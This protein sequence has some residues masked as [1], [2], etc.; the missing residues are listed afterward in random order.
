MTLRSISAFVFPD[1]TPSKIESSP[2]VYR[3]VSPLDLYVDETY[4]RN[5]SRRSIGLI[6]RILAGWDWRA[7]KPP[8][9]VDVEGSLHLI[10][11][12]H[13]ALAAACHPEIARIPVQVVDADETQ[14][15]EAFVRHNRDRISVTPVQL[16]HAMRAAGDS[17]AQAVDRVC[18][19]A[20]ITIV[21]STQAHSWSPGET[22]SVSTIAALIK[23]QGEES[24]VRVLR[25][26]VDAK[27]A[28]VSTSAILAVEALVTGDEYRG[29]ISAGDVATILRRMGAEADRAARI[30]AARVKVPVWRGLATVIFREKT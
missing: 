9:A 23:R 7:F 8:V 24:A 13:T 21:R 30:E 4:Q 25:A 26:C 29:E 22:M 16:H 6:K 3:E 18:N 28:P 14:R 1:V 15:A 17:G 11:G 19:R 12:Q 5:L 20:G 2:P 10:D 27:L